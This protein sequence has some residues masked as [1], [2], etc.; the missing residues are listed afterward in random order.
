[1]V[2]FFFISMWYCF[3][4]LMFNL[5]KNLD[6]LK[7]RA[8]MVKWKVFFIIFKGLSFLRSCLRPRSM[9][10]KKKLAFGGYVYFE[11]FCAGKLSSAFY[12]F[13]NNNILYCNI[14]RNIS[15]LQ[16]ELDNFDWDE[17]ITMEIEN[18]INDGREENPSRLD[19]FRHAASEKMYTSC[20][21]D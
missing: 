3:V 19:N 9:P 20:I 18:V 5:D 1:M 10:L 7:R 6:I 8:F 17:K 16:P 15:N 11:P 12:H 21:I 2:V 4:K 14:N 13:F